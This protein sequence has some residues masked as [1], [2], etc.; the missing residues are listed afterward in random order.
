MLNAATTV[1]I[2]VAAFAAGF[3]ADKIGRRK[4]VLAGCLLC[5]IGIF[6]QGFANSIM[7]L[8][9]GKLISTLGYGLGHALSPVYVAEIVPDNLRGICLTLVVS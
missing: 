9:G 6:V 1:G 4:V 3:I 2:F 8:F 5:I 7:M